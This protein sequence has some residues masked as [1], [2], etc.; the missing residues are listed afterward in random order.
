MAGF[1]IVVPTFNSGEYIK[2][3]I[4]SVQNQA[5]PDFELLIVDGGST[6]TGFLEWIKSLNDTRVKFFY[7]EARLTIEE[8]WA[9]IKDIPKREFFTIL[10]HDDVLFPDLSLTR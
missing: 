8:N 10:G 7:S 4:L 1:S 2:D 3:C 5:L 9:R 6:E